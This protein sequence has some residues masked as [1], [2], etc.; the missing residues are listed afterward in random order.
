MTGSANLYDVVVCWRLISK[1]PPV[2]TENHQVHVILG[3]EDKVPISPSIDLPR[4]LRADSHRSRLAES[5]R[6]LRRHGEIVAGGH[7][8]PL[9]GVVVRLDDNAPSAS[10]PNECD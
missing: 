2:K 7:H 10:R 8:M 3:L 4:E 1:K 9:A 5:L 6:R